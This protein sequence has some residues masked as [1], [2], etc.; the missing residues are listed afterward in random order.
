[1][2]ETETKERIVELFE[3]LVPASGKA[4][5]VAGELARAA[6]RI[7]HRFLNDGDRIGDNNYGNTT[8]NPPARYIKAH[9]NKDIAQ[10]VDALWGWCGP[11]DAYEA[12]MDRLCDM[13]ADY[14]DEHPE[15]REQPTDDM[16]DYTSDDDVVQWEEGDDEW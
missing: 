10:M 11:D 7:G 9:T 14:I 8:C 16:W 15:T 12:V 13:V 5:S 4:D 2:A 1:M 6:N 3:E